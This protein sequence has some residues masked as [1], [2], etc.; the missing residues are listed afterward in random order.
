MQIVHDYRALHSIPEL[1][2]ALPKTLSYIQKQLTPL[3]CRIFSPAEG[4]LCGYFDFG[5]PGTLAFRADTDALPV[6]ENTGLPWRSRHPGRMHACGHDGHT[7]VLL[8][9]ARRLRQKRTLPYN[10]LLIF[11]PAEETDGG[12]KDIC[13]SDVLQQYQVHAIFGLHLWPGLPKGQLFSRPGVLMSRSRSIRVC[14]T[15]CS[16][17]IA[18][19]A[20]GLDALAACC[21][22]YCRTGML[23]ER[24]PYLLKFGKLSG[25]TAGNILCEKAALWG[26]LRTLR[27]P[28]DGRLTHALTGLCR[29]AAE[30]TGCRGEIAFSA[31]YPAVC[32]DSALWQQVQEKCPVTRID[33][34][35]WTADDFSFYQ[36]NVPGIYF[37]LGTGDTP[38]LHSPEFTFDETILSPAADYLESL[39]E[40]L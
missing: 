10:I 17:H 14:F 35:F 24:E 26:S 33:R 4:A 31:G 21:R 30:K 40:M 34:V 9:L 23:R 29:E 5:K 39:C 36:K 32:N 12:A 27:E 1:D 25:G 6:Q 7:A 8:E 13:S 18:N 16:A 3:G 28:V 11:Q 38:P 19:S 37:L 2:R 15:G 20:R 22:F